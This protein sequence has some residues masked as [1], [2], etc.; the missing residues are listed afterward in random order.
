MRATRVL[1][2][3]SAPDASTAGDTGVLYGMAGGALV[4]LTLE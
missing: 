4:R 1:L 2:L 3:L